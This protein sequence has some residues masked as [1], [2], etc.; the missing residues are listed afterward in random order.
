VE[1]VAMLMHRVPDLRLMVQ[2]DSRFLSQF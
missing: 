2:G 1:R